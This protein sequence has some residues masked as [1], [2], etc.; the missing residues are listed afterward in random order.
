LEFVSTLPPEQ[1]YPALG[2]WPEGLD[3]NEAF[4]RGQ[5]Y[6]PNRIEEL[7]GPTVGAQLVRQ[8]VQLFALLLWG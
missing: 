8:L 6:G 3:E 1:V 2:T 7:P 4:A 5:A